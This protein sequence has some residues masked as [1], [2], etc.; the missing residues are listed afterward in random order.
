MIACR[1]SFKKLLEIT[2][3]ENA[4]FHWGNSSEIGAIVGLVKF[5]FKKPINCS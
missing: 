4:I 3:I 5:E 2:P 1:E